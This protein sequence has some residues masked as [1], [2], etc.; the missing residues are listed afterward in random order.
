MPIPKTRDV[1][2]TIKFL[3]K[4]KPSMP[5]KQK[6]AIALETARSAGAKIPQKKETKSISRV[7]RRL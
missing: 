5:K 6:L 1:G 3:K 7:S 2:K 4:E